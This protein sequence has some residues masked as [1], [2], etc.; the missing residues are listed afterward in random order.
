[1]SQIASLIERSRSAEVA[2]VAMMLTAG[3]STLE[4]TRD[5]AALNLAEAEDNLKR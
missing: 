5:E 2:Q 3:V 1:M 4:K